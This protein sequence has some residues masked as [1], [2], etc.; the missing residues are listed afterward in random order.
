[1]KSKEVLSHFRSIDKSAF[2][3]FTKKQ[4]KQYLFV[5]KVKNT[6][7]G[8][9]TH[10]ET[11]SV[12]D[13]V[14]HKSKTFCPYCKEY[15]EI[16]CT[17]YSRKY[18]VQQGYFMRFEQSVIDG[19]LVAR[20][21]YAVRDLSKDY[22][23]K[24]IY[25]DKDYYIFTPK[26]VRASLRSVWYSLGEG[27]ISSWYRADGYEIVN[28]FKEGWDYFN[29]RG[30]DFYSMDEQSF[31]DADK[32]DLKYS[33]WESWGQKEI[34]SYLNMYIKWPCVEYLSK[35]GF[36][37]L[38]TGYLDGEQTQKTI[39]WRGKS[40]TSVLKCSKA[41][42]KVLKDMA[43][44]VTFDFLWEMKFCR[45]N[46]VQS[47]EDILWLMEI[48]RAVRRDLVQYVK[49]QN[50]RRYTEK[51]YNRRF[52][53]DEYDPEDD[54]YNEFTQEAHTEQRQWRRLRDIASEWKD[55]LD[56]AQKL[57]MDMNDKLVLFPRDL[58][59]EHD[60]L[61]TLIKVKKSKELKDKII[62]RC[63]ELEYLRFQVNGLIIRPAESP[64]QLMYEGKRLKHCVATYAERHAEGQTT[65]MFIRKASDPNTPYYTVEIQ[66]KSIIQ[67]RG[68]KNCD[69]TPEIKEFMELFR[70]HRLTKKKNRVRVPA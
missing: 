70:E 55:Y 27:K 33:G 1:M 13:T 21:L 3:E 8:Y 4:F 46:G 68:Y 41:D 18:F 67:C 12:V 16:R 66:G 42:I 11:I 2:D 10:C 20:G 17:S 36:K 24:P 29:F 52:P 47:I 5:T 44:K 6:Y 53:E 63:K 23:S 32:G 31:K 37:R 34:I 50:V 40:L 69:Q 62:K 60:K 9:C 51:Q 57:N 59:R 14:K 26:P 30:M 45:D 19:S 65:I 25:K 61:A 15:V 64:A 39:N 22:K 49:L 43:S 58:Q 35:L 54:P 56:M 7:E 28:S 38:I 48:Y